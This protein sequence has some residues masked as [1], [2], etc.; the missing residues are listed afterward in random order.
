MVESVVSVR[1][2][3]LT[4]CLVEIISTAKAVHGKWN[5]VVAEENLNSLTTVV[6]GFVKSARS[7]VVSLTAFVVGIDT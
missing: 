1:R 6:L 5:V 2:I 3:G 7:I 4:P